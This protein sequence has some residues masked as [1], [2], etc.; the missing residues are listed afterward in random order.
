MFK[1]GSGPVPCALVRSHWFM[2][3]GLYTPKS[4]PFSTYSQCFT[5]ANRFPLPAFE[6]LS[7]FASCHFAVSQPAF[8][9]AHLGFSF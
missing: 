7:I 9:H 2:A 5:N 6:C 4:M 1:V 3:N 8:Y